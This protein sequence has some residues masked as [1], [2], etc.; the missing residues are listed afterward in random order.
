[1]IGFVTYRTLKHKKD[2][3]ISDIASVIAAIGGATIVG[4]FPVAE[5]RFDEYAIGLAFGF[6]FFLVVFW[7]L[8]ALYGSGQAA[9][10]QLD[11]DD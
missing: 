3:G 2:A 4:L 6:F 11:D 8:T 5:G 7:V 10:Q 9:T 1:V